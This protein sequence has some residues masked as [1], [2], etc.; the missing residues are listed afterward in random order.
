MGTNCNI[1]NVYISNTNVF[2]LFFLDKV[3]ACIQCA[4]IFQEDSERT[5]C[6]LRNQHTIRTCRGLRFAKQQSSQKSCPLHINQLMLKGDICTLC[7]P[8]VKILG[9]TRH[10]IQ[11]LTGDTPNYI[12][13]YGV[14]NSQP[15][16]Y[17]QQES[18][19]PLPVNE[20]VTGSAIT[21]GAPQQ[22]TGDLDK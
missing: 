7:R 17:V 10:E 20:N 3:V 14:D 9:L 15:Y 2:L 18:L 12:F 6:R 11:H 22:E 21:A 13:L 1:E 5:N 4:S 16:K 19:V 8:N